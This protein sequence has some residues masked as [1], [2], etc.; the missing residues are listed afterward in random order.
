MK[1]YHTSVGVAVEPEMYR[2][3]K[4][5]A[6]LKKVS[7]SKLIREGIGIRLDRVDQENRALIQGTPSDK[8]NSG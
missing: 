4:R 3:L 8:S 5:A 2:R 6:S 1:R 7:M